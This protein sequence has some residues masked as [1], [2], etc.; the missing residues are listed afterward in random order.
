MR[1]VDVHFPHPHLDPGARVYRGGEMIQLLFL[2]LLFM[3]RFLN[4]I[5]FPPAS[6]LGVRVI[7]LHSPV[8]VRPSN[9]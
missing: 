8:Q 9:R 6:Y 7:P 4:V 3:V 1:R 5:R 2:I